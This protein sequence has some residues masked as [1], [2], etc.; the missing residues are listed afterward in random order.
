MT[1][2]VFASSEVGSRAATRVRIKAGKYEG[3]VGVVVRVVG[4]TLF[5]RLN[6]HTIPFGTCE[7]EVQ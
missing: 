6:E 7:V 5:V 2:E 1:R 3:R 4:T